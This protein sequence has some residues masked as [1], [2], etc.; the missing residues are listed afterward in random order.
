MNGTQATQENAEKNRMMKAP[1]TPAFP[2]RCRKAY[3]APAQNPLSRPTADGRVR[4][5]DSPGLITNNAPAKAP[6]THKVCRNPIRSPTSSQ[7]NTR[8]KNGAVLLSAIAS[9]IGI[10]EMA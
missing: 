10:W 6:S 9:A 1:L 5:P 8:V 3:A 4:L 7:L 2:N